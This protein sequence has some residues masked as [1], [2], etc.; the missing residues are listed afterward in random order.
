VARGRGLGVAQIPLAMLAG[1][2]RMDEETAVRARRPRDP[3]RQ[4]ESGRQNETVVVVGVFPDEIHAPGRP[5][6]PWGI[7]EPLAKPRGQTLGN[8]NEPQ[9]NADRR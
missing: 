1:V 5:V 4:T 3:G 8:Q 6:D 9:I 7:P 2:L